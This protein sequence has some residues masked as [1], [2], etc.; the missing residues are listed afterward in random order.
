MSKSDPEREARLAAELR[1]NLRRRKTDAAGP[2]PPPAVEP[3]LDPD[4]LERD[5]GEDASPPPGEHVPG[6][7]DENGPRNPA[8]L[9]PPD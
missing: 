9:L 7:D 6:R 1:A 5:R 8:T 4:D 2:V 3:G